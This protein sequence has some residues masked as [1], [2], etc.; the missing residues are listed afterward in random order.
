MTALTGQVGSELNAICGKCG[1]VWHVVI[2]L[3]DRRIV[4]V[5]CGECGARHR[6]RPSRNAAA[7]DARPHNPTARKPAS[8]ARKNDAAPVVEADCSRPC[9]PFQPIDTYQAGDRMLHPT[10]G[11]GVVQA[12]RGAK[13]V[14][15]LFEAGTKL[16]VQGHP[17]G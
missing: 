13:K 14:E 11:E 7:G 16:L 3:A 8:R 10:F 17:K 6:Y 12:T 5:Q 15:V 4:Q 9:R 1:D 2:A